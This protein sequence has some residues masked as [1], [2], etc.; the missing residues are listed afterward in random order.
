MY[1]TAVTGRV[2]PEIEKGVAEWRAWRVATV[3]GH[4]FTVA[5]IMVSLPVVAGIAL[6]FH[7][8]GLAWLLQTN[9]IQMIEQ[10][11]IILSSV[12]ASIIGK[13]LGIGAFILWYN[14]HEKDARQRLIMVWLMLV[15]LGALV[16]LSVGQVPF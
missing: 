16:F 1:Q 5:D 6:S 13:V 9:A 2:A 4:T 12:S 3:Y 10:K 11:Q 14:N 8:A 15:L 7:F